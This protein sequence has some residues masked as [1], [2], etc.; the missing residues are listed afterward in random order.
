MIWTLIYVLTITASA[1]VPLP[2]HP[3]ITRVETNK[4]TFECEKFTSPYEL[5][6]VFYT[7]SPAAK[8][9]A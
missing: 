5:A 8:K 3:K 7:E 4:W 9:L 1:F 2:V 6:K